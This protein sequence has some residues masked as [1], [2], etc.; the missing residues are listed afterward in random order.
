[1]KKLTNPD[2]PSL[3]EDDEDNEDNQSN[4]DEEEERRF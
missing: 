3:K 1:L 4:L 2:D